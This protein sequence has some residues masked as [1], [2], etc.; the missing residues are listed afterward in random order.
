VADLKL[1][2]DALLEHPLKSDDPTPPVNWTLGPVRGVSG[3]K[4]GVYTDNDVFAVSPCLKRAVIDCANA[5]REAGL[6]VVDFQPPDLAEGFRLYMTLLCADGG[7]WVNKALNSE[8]PIA[9][10]QSLLRAA[11]M[12]NYLRGPAA[13]LLNLLGQQH[14]A[15][16]IK[17][18][19]HYSAARYWQLCAERAN[20]RTSFQRAMDDLDLDIL[21]CPPYA[22]PAPRLNNNTFGTN[23]LGCSHSAIYNL[24]GNP[25]G[26]VSITRVLDHE[27]IGRKPGR[28]KAEQAAALN[29]QNSAGLPVGVQVVGR[30]WR[31]DQVLAVMQELENSFKEREDYPLGK[32]SLL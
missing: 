12:P 16:M 24:L 23:S 2:M 28:D 14:A 4:I 9:D 10:V 11:G 30:C 26:V 20:Y 29:E 3:L 25:A 19:G 7:Q 15:R 18:P 22:T 6:S 8:T 1:F 5:L 21:L 31:E 27:Q 17:V 13:W 32:R